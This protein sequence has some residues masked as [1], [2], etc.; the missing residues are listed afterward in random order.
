MWSVKNWNGARSPYSSPMNSIG[1]KG[2]S[3]VQQRGQRPRRRGQPVAERAVADLVVVLGEH[4]ELLGR[5]VVGGRAEAAPRNSDQSPSCT[6]GRRN[7]L[8]S[9][10]TVAEVRV[11]AV[12][13]AGEQ[14]AQRVVEVVGPLRVA[15]AAAGRA[16]RM[17]FGSLSP[18]SAITS[19][20][21]RAAWTRS[22]SSART[23]SALVST[24]AWIASRRS[25]STWKSRTQPS[26]LWSTHSRTGSEPASSKLIASPHGVA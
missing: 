18:L 25:P 8:A 15:A 11:V 24:I 4:D 21:G 9:C 14:D 17:T 7:A 12:A 16:A 26:A 2:D 13:L 6:C 5:P 1:V 20:P 10:A 22:A 19:A 3:S 23:C